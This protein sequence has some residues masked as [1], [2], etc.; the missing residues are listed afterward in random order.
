VYKFD[1]FTAPCEV[2]L[3]SDDRIR[4]QNC[5]KDI[6][7]EMKRL[8]KKYNYFDKQSFLS[9]LNT[10][11]TNELDNETKTLLSQSIQFYKKTNGVFDITIATIKNVFD[12][13]QKET[14]LKYVGCEHIT[15][16][17]SKLYFD[18]EKTKIDFGGVV[19]EYGVDRA[20]KIIKKYKIKSALVNFGGDIYALGKKPDGAKF[21]IGIKNPKKINE[22]LFFVELENEALTTSASYERYQEIDGVKHSHIISKQNLDEKILSATVVSKSVL[23]S[24][25]YSTSLMIDK[26]IKTKNKKYLIKYDLSVKR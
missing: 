5:A 13:E 4:A 23:E 22:S 1:V 21:K 10:R 25:V 19:K 6:L 8:E 9:E 14:L 15:I 24:G 7:T 20:V 12:K 26:N 18:N 2:Q 16:K 3:Y 11:V 17:K